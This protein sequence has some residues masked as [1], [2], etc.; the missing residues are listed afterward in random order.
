MSTKN[1][2]NGLRSLVL[3]RSSHQLCWCAVGAAPLPVPGAPAQHRSAWLQ[4][5]RGTFAVPVICSGWN[6]TKH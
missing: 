4:M 5:L 3:L 1:G 6:K 2:L